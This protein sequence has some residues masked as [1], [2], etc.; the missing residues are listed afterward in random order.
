MPAVEYS[1][2]I[3]DENADDQ[4]HTPATCRQAA[5]RLQPPAPPTNPTDGPVHDWFSLSYRNYLVLHRAL[6]QS[7]PTS[8]QER[9]VACLEEFHDAFAHLDHP[10]A[11]QVQAATEHQVAD[12]TVVQQKQLGITEDWFHGELPPEHLAGDELREWEI[13]HED[14]NGPVYYN[15]GRELDPHERVL[16]PARDPIPHY[17]RGRTYIEPHRPLV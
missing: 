16:L 5:L 3:P 8:W 6:M 11:F 4:S 15:D 7:M 9:M 1:V 17:R 13:K 12:L 2:P 14:P 10:E